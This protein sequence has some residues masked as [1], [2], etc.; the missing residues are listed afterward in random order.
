MC[1]N[2]KVPKPIKKY[3]RVRSGKKQKYGLENAGRPGAISKKDKI[4]FYSEIPESKAAQDRSR[5]V[6]SLQDMSRGK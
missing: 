2:Q 6:Q 3:K 5:M 1:K 4:K